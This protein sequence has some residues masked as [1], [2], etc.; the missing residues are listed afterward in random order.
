MTKEI[1]YI[2]RQSM[3]SLNDKTITQSDR[4]K[5]DV[6]ITHH[7]A[8]ISENTE[9]WIVYKGFNRPQNLQSPYTNAIWP[10]YT[11]AIVGE[12]N[13]DACID[14][15][16]LIY[17]GMRGGVLIAN[18]YFPANHVMIFD[19]QQKGTRWRWTSQI[20]HGGRDVPTSLPGN[21]TL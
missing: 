5:L 4:H 1:S 13:E 19:L 8:V 10:W 2:K 3:W 6:D 18:V 14:V 11:W 12:A 7:K 16:W 9:V 21:L 15:E 17:H 20:W